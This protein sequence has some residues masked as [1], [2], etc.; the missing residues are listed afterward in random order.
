MT[1]EQIIFSVFQDHPTKTDPGIQ[2]KQVAECF[3]LGPGGGHPW[4]TTAKVGAGL[5]EATLLGIFHF[6]KQIVVQE[7]QMEKPEE[8][9]HRGLKKKKKRQKGKKQTLTGKCG[10]L[11]MWFRHRLAIFQ[12]KKPHAKCCQL[13]IVPISSPCQSY[14]VADGKEEDDPKMSILFFFFQIRNRS[15][16]KYTKQPREKAKETF[17]EPYSISMEHSLNSNFPTKHSLCS[18]EGF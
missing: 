17:W 13:D 2:P 16:Q 7:T 18:V 9:S 3:R 6:P 11:K 10:H 12:L 15:Y 1:Q 4:K 8:K 14:F 5:M